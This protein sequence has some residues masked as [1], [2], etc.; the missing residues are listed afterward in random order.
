MEELL[1]IEDGPIVELRERPAQGTRHTVIFGVLTDTGERVAV[2]IER[3]PGA[4]D[5][6]RA[7]LAFLGGSN[8]PVPSLFAAGA[9]TIASERVECLV[10][11]RRAG[12]PPTSIE[13]WRR[14]GRA[15][16]RLQ[17]PRTVPAGLP[18]LDRASFGAEHAHRIGELGD[19]IVPFVASIPDWT[20]LSAGRVPGSA[21][22]VL[23]H[24]DPGPGNFLDDGRDGTII[25][26]EEAQIA[27]RGLDLA[28]LVFIALL[29]AGPH[30]YAAHDHRD[31]A[32][33]VARG[34]LDALGDRWRPSRE[35]SRWWITA[36]GVQFIHR[37]WELGGRPAPW[38]DAAH[39]LQTALVQNSTW[40]DT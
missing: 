8:R 27:P 39:V 20:I 7:A 30:G 23:T 17:Q 18:T 29:G 26:W 33:A 5:R 21:P 24:G 22:Q 12:S 15:Y 35:Q 11:Q 34:Y 4:L 37:R 36:A 16:A 14:M 40:P 32:H 6:E 25:D 3:T 10:M 19:L 2:K 1:A 28:R 31:R 13:G 38:Q 9:A